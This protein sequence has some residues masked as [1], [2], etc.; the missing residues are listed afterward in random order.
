VLIAFDADDAGAAG[1]F[2]LV[3]AVGLAAKA[4]SRAAIAGHFLVRRLLAA[5]L[6]R[7]RH[8]PAR[9]AAARRLPAGHA[10]VGG[11][12]GLRPLPL[13]LAVPG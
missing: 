2:A 4:A 9:A 5:G 3:V 13:L 6:V 11:A 7:T 1:L 8:A 12:A 10:G